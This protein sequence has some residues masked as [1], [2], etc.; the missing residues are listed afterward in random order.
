[1]V[2]ERRY[3]DQFE[4]YVSHASHWIKREKVRNPVT[5]KNE[6]PDEELMSE[7][8]RMLEISSGDGKREE[9]R[10]EVISKIG[11]WS[12][13]NPRRKPDYELI[14]PRPIANLREAFF[15]ERKKQIRK[16]NE[17]LLV[18]LVDGPAKMPTDVAEASQRTIDTLKSRFNYCDHCAK[19]AILALVRK[20]YS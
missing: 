6:D 7:V 20:R 3:I 8:E 12:I 4:R 10:R 18:Y 5:G 9:F 2:E 17:D 15:G 19:D 11:A 14:F 13:D 16:N 1:L